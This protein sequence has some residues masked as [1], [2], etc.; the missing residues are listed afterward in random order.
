MIFAEKRVIC[1]QNYN[2][3]GLMYQSSRDYNTLLNEA[4][5]P[6]ELCLF[7]AWFLAMPA[8]WMHHVACRVLNAKA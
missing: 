7:Y 2:T 4:T 8:R 1:S 6:Y 5:C 3:S